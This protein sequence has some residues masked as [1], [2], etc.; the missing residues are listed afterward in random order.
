MVIL[1]LTDL[2]LHWEQ[3]LLY[4]SHWL[5][6]R[7]LI[8]YWNQ[9]C[10]S[11]LLGWHKPYDYHLHNLNP[12]WNKWG[13]RFFQAKTEVSCYSM[14]TMLTWIYARKGKRAEKQEMVFD[15]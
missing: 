3:H 13:I 15:Q 6:A 10:M 14:M 9:V 11:L 8:I 12:T 4:L 5:L 7:N 2:D 1:K